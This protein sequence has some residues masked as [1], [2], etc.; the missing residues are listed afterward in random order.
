MDL[1]GNGGG[2]LEEA[3]SLTGLFIDEGPMVQVKSARRRTSVLADQDRSDLL[4]WPFGSY[5]KPT[6]GSASEIFAGAMQ[7]Y[8]RAVVIGNQTFGKGTV[9]TL[10]PLNRGQ[11]RT[12]CSEILSNL[13]EST[14][15]QGVIPDISFPELY[16]SS[17]IG[18]SSHEDAMPGIR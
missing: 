7:D 13:R 9:Q 1:G 18:E 14:Q 8:G 12:D 16:D 17:K 3:R 2:S 15:H 6:V 10:I 5:G 11:L 4:G